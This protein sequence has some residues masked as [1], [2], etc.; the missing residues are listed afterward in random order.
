MRLRIDYE[1]G[2]EIKFLSQLDTVR[3]WERM[4]RRSKLPVALSQ[5]FNPHLKLSLGTV[6]PVGVWG[7]HEYL[8]VELSG[9]VPVEKALECLRKAAP[10]GIRIHSGREIFQHAAAL[11]AAVNAASYRVRLEAIDE[12]VLDCVKQ[13]LAADELMVENLRKREVINIRPR[14]HAIRMVQEPGFAGLEVWGAGG[15]DGPLRV[16]DLLLVLDRNG[17]SGASIQE[18]WREGNYVFKDGVYLD[19]LAGV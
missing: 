11:M 4:L 1:K 5:G 17:L 15:G 7:R 19:M 9:S 14:I 3:V 16:Q 2:S 18:V 6:L 10:P 13:V 8:D 12:A